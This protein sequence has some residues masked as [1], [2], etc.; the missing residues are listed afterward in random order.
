MKIAQV[1]YAQ[2]WGEVTPATI[3]QGLGGRETAMIKLAEAWA[4]QGNEVSNFVNVEK[5]SRF[6]GQFKGYHEYLPITMTKA[7]LGN[8]PWDAVVAWEIPSIFEDDDIRENARVKV[9]EMQV[10]HF[11]EREMVAAE[12]YCDYVAALSD[13]H[14]QFLTHSGLNM[15]HGKVITLPNGIDATRY[16]GFEYGQKRN[17]HKVDAFPKFV[18]S[19]SPDRGLLHILTSWKAIR[20]SFPGAELLVCYGLEDYV[21]KMKWAHSRQAEMCLQIEELIKQPG[22]QNLEKIGQKELARL[23]ME[24]T[25]WLYP[26]DA[27]A[28]TETGCITAIENAA[29]GNPLIISNGDCLESEFGNFSYVIDLPFNQDD[30]VK[31]VET[32]LGDTT[33]YREMQ[34]LGREFALTRTWGRI[35]KKWLD[36]F[37]KDRY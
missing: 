36:I 13:W 11:G 25:A 32:V 19:S 15:K 4:E 20:K 23:Q 22:V 21:D 24:A 30:L 29:A 17:S 10:A 33:M 6:P 8:M 37:E 26:L 31:G 12:S 1:L 27:L 35:G 7:M 16:L 34:A 28:P 14:G 5:G 3:E 2:S 18:Y 9:C